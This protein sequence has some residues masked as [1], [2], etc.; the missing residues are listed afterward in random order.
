MQL[1]FELKGDCYSKKLKEIC[2]KKKS[3]RNKKT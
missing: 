3:K 2:K 1:E